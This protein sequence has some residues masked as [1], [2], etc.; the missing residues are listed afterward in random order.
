MSVMERAHGR[1]ENHRMRQFLRHRPD[2]GDLANDP[3][4]GFSAPSSS[5]LKHPRSGIVTHL[6]RLFNS[7]RSSYKTFWIK[8]LRSKRFKSPRS[9]GTKTALSAFSR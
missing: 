1:N 4:A 6:G 9:L 2:P 3:H 8:A 7:Y 5:N